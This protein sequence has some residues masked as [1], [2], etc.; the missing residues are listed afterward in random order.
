M[1]QRRGEKGNY[2][3]EGFNIVA[4]AFG[5]KQQQ[6]V[7]LEHPF[8]VYKER[9]L[10]FQCTPPAHRLI[11]ASSLFTTPYELARRLFDSFLL[12]TLAS[13]FISFSCR[14]FYKVGN[15]HRPFRSS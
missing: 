1:H 3:R 10:P 6:S 4:Q 7:G 15:S 2:N 13:S 9:H 11:R 14:F 5:P 8:V 12:L